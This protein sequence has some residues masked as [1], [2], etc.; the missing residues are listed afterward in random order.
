MFANTQM[1]R[2]DPG[3][4]ALTPLRSLGLMARRTSDRAT[5]LVIQAGLEAMLQE[6]R[7]LNAFSHD[8]LTA[9]I[10]LQYLRSRTGRRP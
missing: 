1:M 6:S 3:Y 9:E 10:D 2:S 5:L 8:H 7:S 4:P